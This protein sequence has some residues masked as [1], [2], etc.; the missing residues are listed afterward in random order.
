MSTLWDFEF[1][2]MAACSLLLC[3]SYNGSQVPCFDITCLYG[4]AAAAAEGIVALCI[5]ANVFPKERLAALWEGPLSNYFFVM[6]RLSHPH[7]NIS[8]DTI[9]QLTFWSFEKHHLYIV[10][11]IHGQEGGWTTLCTSIIHFMSLLDVQQ[12]QEY[13]IPKILLFFFPCS[14]ADGFSNLWQHHLSKLMQ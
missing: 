7:P 10:T 9:F 4:K 13:T 11:N 6:L 12:K 3:K 2:V 5:P 8:N 1:V 14:L